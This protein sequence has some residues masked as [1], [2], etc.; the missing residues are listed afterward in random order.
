MSTIH[1]VLSGA[2]SSFPRGTGNLSAVSPSRPVLCWGNCLTQWLAANMH[3]E[4]GAQRPG[5][6]VSAL[7]LQR[8]IPVP[9]L[10]SRL[11]EDSYCNCIEAQLPPVFSLAFL[12]GL[13]PG[14][15]PNKSPALGWSQ[16]FSL[17]LLL[18]FWFLT[19]HFFVIV[20]IK[21]PLQKGG[22]FW[23]KDPCWVSQ[24]SGVTCGNGVSRERRG[25][26]LQEA[27]GNYW[28]CSWTGRKWKWKSLSCVQLF[29]NS[30]GQWVAFPFSRGSS[31]PR[32]RTQVSHIAGKFFTSWVT[33]EAKE[34]WSG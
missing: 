5:P 32:D 12:T 4:M 24:G 16:Q 33:R 6:L 14:A 9:E 20:V 10:S 3:V 15:H 11:A 13:F 31:Q 25:S 19:C 23:G 30:P 21:T 34:Y 1:M 27:G 28:L 17:L 2:G 26:G 18:L 7:W 29:A 8:D 22:V